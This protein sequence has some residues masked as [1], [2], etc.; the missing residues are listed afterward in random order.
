MDLEKLIC[1]EVKKQTNSTEFK[2]NMQAKVKEMPSKR[3]Y[4][5][6]KKTTY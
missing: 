1:D 5:I 6:T 3:I 4:I 2:E